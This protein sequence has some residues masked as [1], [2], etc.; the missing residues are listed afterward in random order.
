MKYTKFTLEN[1]KGISKPVVIDIGGKLKEPL[2]LVGNNESGKTTILKGIELIGKLC[3]GHV[4]KSGEAANYRPKV[5]IDFTGKIEL[6]VGISFD[7][8]DIKDE[9]CAKIKPLKPLA[10]YRSS[11]QTLA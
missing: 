5:G 7:T 2:C 1:F 4:L 10:N 9:V 6:G 11:A 8:L 3:K